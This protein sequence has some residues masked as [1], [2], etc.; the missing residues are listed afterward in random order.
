MADVIKKSKKRIPSHAEQCFLLQN[1]DKFATQKGDTLTQDYK[2]FALLDPN[3]Q[4]S[5]AFIN[6]IRGLGEEGQRFFDSLPKTIAGDLQP[7]FKLFKVIP[8]KPGKSNAFKDHSFPLPFNNIGFDITGGNKKL[9]VAFRSF[10]FDF[11]GRRPV[12]VDAYVRC[13]LRLYF[14]SPDALMHRYADPNLENGVAFSDL[15]ARPFLIDDTPHDHLEYDEKYFRIKAVVGYEPPEMNRLIEAYRQAKVTNPKKKAEELIIALRNSRFEIFLTL[16]KHTVEPRFDSAD[17]GYELSIEYIGALET[18]FN[19]KAAD[20]LGTPQTIQ[21]IALERE[22]EVNIMRKRE[23]AFSGLSHADRSIVEAEASHGNFLEQSL[24]QYQT[25]KNALLDQVRAGN[26]T[27]SGQENSIFF[28][29]AR[30]M[31]LETMTNE[32]AM[33]AVASIDEKKIKAQIV[34][35]LELESV[36]YT[37]Q[38]D[39]IANYL[40]YRSL[41]ETFKQESGIRSATQLSDIYRKF[42]SRLNE[43]KKLYVTTLRNADFENWFLYSDGSDKKSK[44]TIDNEIKKLLDE[45]STASTQRFAEIEIEIDNLKLDLEDRS[46]ME[47]LYNSVAQRAAESVTT[48]NNIEAINA[49][50]ET[51]KKAA[52]AAAAEVKQKE[53]KTEPSTDTDA[54]ADKTV[55]T[56][57]RD[58]DVY[59]FFY[60]DLLDAA[61]EILQEKK[62]ELMLDMWSSDN[63]EGNVKVLLGEIEFY[64]PQ[65]GKRTKESLAKIPISLKTWEKFWL[66]KVVSP[67][68]T[69]Y[70]F[71]SFL[72]DT[73]SELIVDAMSNKCK[74][75]G[76]TQLI[77]RT[78]IHY[79]TLK[80]NAQLS[81]EQLSSAGKNDKAYYHSLAQEV[82]T[83][84]TKPSSN[85][86]PTRAELIFIHAPSSTAK[87]FN[88]TK[89]K[90]DF[91]RGVHH[92]VLGAENTPIISAQFE[93]SNQPYYLE[94]KAEVG[95]TLN[96]TVHFSE[97]Y[98]CSI[99]MLGNSIITPGKHLHISLPTSHFGKPGAQNSA[100]RRL[101]LGGYFFILNTGNE[102]VAQESRFEWV[103]QLRCRWES[104]GDEEVKP[105][106]LSTKHVLE[107]PDSITRRNIPGE[108]LNLPSDLTSVGD[109]GEDKSLAA[110]RVRQA[111]LDAGTLGSENLEGSVLYKDPQERAK[112]DAQLE[113]R[114]HQYKVLLNTPQTGNR[115]EDRKRAEVILELYK[116]LKGAGKIK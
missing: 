51:V 9:G 106:S 36:E 63:Q 100:A 60:G 99:R 108:A 38:I 93:K 46:S 74:D 84:T 102:L 19:S 30:S 48:A 25:E 81:F 20:I 73:L 66:D 89:P 94:A 28:S 4:E 111:T 50:T 62:Q 15:I 12:E 21:Q 71:K 7:Y 58:K 59:Y 54:A 5:T 17:G 101:G 41:Y 91:K 87:W 103:T 77:V 107:P 105:D 18:S 104:F 52:E 27:L 26:V 61:L 42:V 83:E 34:R 49:S 72:H 3:K 64:H 95:A 112:L 1:I 14:E 98:N 56:S 11:E 2:H 86:K 68:K 116:I 110:D 22:W 47:Q 75:R 82:L 115:E 40:E 53:E 43:K 78:A 96:D 88:S 97:P 57:I 69:E 31:G 65:T 37:Q 35:G 44:R 10:S 70:F 55:E 114:L 85:G 45:A 29:I 8:H 39:K 79:E 24:K 33:K 113:Q 92:I 6:T 23:K 32:Q 13:N 16:L 80:N 76:D 90:E 109:I 67:L